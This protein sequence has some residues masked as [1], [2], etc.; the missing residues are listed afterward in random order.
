MFRLGVA[1]R[2][3]GVIV[4]LFVTRTMDGAAP[5]VPPELNVVRGGARVRSSL[6]PLRR[7]ISSTRPAAVIAAR[8]YVNIVAAAAARTSRSR[9]IVIATE[10]TAA[11]VEELHDPNRMNGPVRFLRRLAYPFVDHVVA[12]SSAVRADLLAS[13]PA[14]ASKVRVIPNPVVSAE[15]RQ[16]AA[17]PIDRSIADSIAGFSPLLVSVG[18]L[19]AQ[20]DQRTLLAAFARVRARFPTAG[21]VLIGE[22]PLRQDLN[23]YSEHLGISHAVIM[24]GYLENP[25]PLMRA[26]DMLVQ[27]S[28][29]EGLPTVLV[30]ALALGTRVAAT[31]C[32]GVTD[33]LGSEQ[34]GTLAPVGDTE[35]LARAIESELLQ[36][37]AALD[38]IAS[39]DRFRADRV[40]CQYL[41]LI[42]T[43]SYGA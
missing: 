8:T 3:Q 13:R 39:A 10:R 30:E 42:T 22:G 34:F 4:D 33:V 20:K 15:L 29:W 21:M 16:A 7:Y 35:A 27:S 31:D 2:E 25:F 43:N 28:R 17:L 24:P 40:A 41:E 11:S 37:R 14:W 36:P 1:M 38:L 19:T 26:A 9:P 23:A 18:R 5:A 32:P 12:V 6:L